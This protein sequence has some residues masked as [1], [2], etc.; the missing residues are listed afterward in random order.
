MTGTVASSTGTSLSCVALVT[1]Y[2][3]NTRAACTITATAAR[4]TPNATTQRNA[5]S[6]IRL[7]RQRATGF[8]DDV[9]FPR[10]SRYACL[11]ASTASAKVSL[12]RP[13]ASLPRSMMSPALSRSSEPRL[14]RYSFPSSALPFSSS[15]VS[16]PAFGAKSRPTP[17]PTPNPKRKLGRQLSFAMMFLL[18]ARLGRRTRRKP[19]SDQFLFQ[20]TPRRAPI[21][22]VFS[23]STV[24]TRTQFLSG[25]RRG[26]LLGGNHHHEPAQ[27]A[28][29][30]A[31]GNGQT[32]GVGAEDPGRTCLFVGRAAP[33]AARP[34][35]ACRGCGYRHRPAEGVRLPGR[36]ALRG[37]LHRGASRE[38]R[39]RQGPG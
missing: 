37:R 18:V 11:P 13:I 14:L 17:I 10:A 30:A 33:E 24:E 4:N 20:Y 35:G 34:C 23:T 8:S 36:P 39:P 9:E 22:G 6:D 29:P 12:W 16:Y 26:K 25:R 27:D 31:P 19:P 32:V 3:A 7:V 15:R 1:R 5:S 38:P 28:R 2:M 21:A